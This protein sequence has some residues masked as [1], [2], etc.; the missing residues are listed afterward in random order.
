MNAG[1]KKQTKQNKKQTTTAKISVVLKQS[2]FLTDKHLPGASGLGRQTLLKWQDVDDQPDF[3][4]GWTVQLG[5][6]G[7]MVMRKPALAKK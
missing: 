7:K 2:G 4:A 6:G 5:R 3:S 1:P